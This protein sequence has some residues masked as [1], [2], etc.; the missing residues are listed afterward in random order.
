[1]EQSKLGSLIETCINTVIGFLVTFIAWP[2][3]ALLTGIEYN[4]GQ[5][6]GVVA[7]FTVISV[8]RGYVVRRW[9]NARLKEAATRLAQSLHHSETKG[10]SR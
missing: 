7:F 2:L 5:Q 3:A 6:F 10:A 4:Y 9:F 8:A 1:M